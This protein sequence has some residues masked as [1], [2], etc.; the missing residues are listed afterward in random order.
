[1][2]VKNDLDDVLTQHCCYSTGIPLL[3]AINTS[4]NHSIAK[5]LVVFEAWLSMQSCCLLGSTRHT[6]GT[7]AHLGD[8]AGAV[9]CRSSSFLVPPAPAN[10]ASFTYP[11]LPGSLLSRDARPRVG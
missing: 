5:T 7:R 9:T 3:D 10:Y 11:K 8:I 4:T 1:M 2:T 6:A